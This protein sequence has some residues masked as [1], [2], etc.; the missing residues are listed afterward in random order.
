MM[1]KRPTKKTKKPKKTIVKTKPTAM[2]VHI[3]AG[4]F[5]CGIKQAGFEV[6]S[7]LEGGNYGVTTA[8][9]NWPSLPIYVGEESWPLEQYEGKVDFVYCNP[10]CAIFSSAGISTTRGADYWRND[11]RVDCWRQCFTVLEKVRPKVWAMESV[12]QAYT[13]GKELID[14]FT[15]AAVQMGYSVQHILMDAK[16]TGIPQSRRRFFIICHRPEVPLK[17]GF[18]Y[19]KELA[20]I[21]SC[22]DTVIEP[23][24]VV[25]RKRKSPFQKMYKQCVRLCQPGQKLR[26]VFD[27]IAPETPGYSLE[28][29]NGKIPGRPGFLTYRLDSTTQMGAFIGGVFLHPT[30]NRLLGVNEMKAIC[31]YPDSFK[32]AGTPGQHSSLLARAVLPTVGNWLGRAVGRALRRKLPEGTKKQQVTLWDLRKPESAASPVDLTEDYICISKEQLIE[33][34]QAC[35]SCPAMSGKKRCLSEKNGNW[36][37]EIVF[38]AEAPGL[39]GANRHGIPLGGVGPS[40]EFFK[41]MLKSCGYKRHQVFVTNAVLCAP[42]EDGK[43]RRPT[44]Q[45]LKACSSHLIRTLDI[46]QPKIV[47][48][49]GRIAVN[50]LKDIYPF[51]VP[52][53]RSNMGV[54]IPWN[55]RTLFMLYHPSP[56]T[57]KKRS[58]LGQCTDMKRV[59]KHLK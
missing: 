15:K 56:R 18:N 47:V 33:E 4:G 21:G 39:Q 52:F 16:Y 3:F 25:E 51:N 6:I 43:I 26:D 55:G 42:S 32:L 54:P 48:A 36:D 1:P 20:T 35:C 8:K 38:V 2:G 53:Q 28:P 14:Q 10:P 29:V 45:E 11:P 37:S 59:F 41:A 9:L 23:G 31:G 46:I 49:M 12:P 57:F 17:L 50:A 44:H 58:R 13:K 19:S 27:R 22:L 30:E 40:G 5:T 34:A 24:F 7:H